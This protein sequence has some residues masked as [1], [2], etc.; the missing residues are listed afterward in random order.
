[1]DSLLRSSCISLGCWLVRSLSNSLSKSPTNFTNQYA[2]SMIWVALSPKVFT[3]PDPCFD[4]VDD[5]DGDDD[6]GE[7][8]EDT[9]D[10]DM[11]GKDEKEDVNA[12]G[13]VEDDDDD[14]KREEEEEEEGGSEVQWTGPS[15]LLSIG[16]P[17]KVPIEGSRASR[18][19]SG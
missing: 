9:N 7:V 2:I 5:D 12:T 19:A 6:D 13:E 18:E 4:V 16:L 8:N 1:M 15:D 14:E 11:E 10:D 17:G 3:F